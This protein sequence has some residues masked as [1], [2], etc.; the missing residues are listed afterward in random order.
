VRNAKAG[1]NLVLRADT[2]GHHL[3]TGSDDKIVCM[4]HGSEVHIAALHFTPSVPA[5]MQFDLRHLIGQPVSGTF[6]SYAADR[7]NI[8][9]YH[10]VHFLYLAA[11]TRFYIGP[12]KPSLI[13]R[14]GLDALPPEPKPEGEDTPAAPAQE[15]APEPVQEPAPAPTPET[16]TA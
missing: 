1:E 16:V 8:A 15:P 14:L 13:E 11:G 7:I 3:P 10:E 9:N 2:N 4:P 5:R 6:S 12:K